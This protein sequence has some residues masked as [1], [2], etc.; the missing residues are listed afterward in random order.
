MNLGISIFMALSRIKICIEYEEDIVVEYVGAGYY[1]I[2][3][4]VT[5]I[6]NG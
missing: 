2:L 3:C 4:L 6:D 5:L 1:Q